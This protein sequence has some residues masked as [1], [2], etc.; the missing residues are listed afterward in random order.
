MAVELKYQ[1][2]FT[3]TGD[4]TLNMRADLMVC[5]PRR[6]ISCDFSIE[7]VHAL[8]ALN[9]G[10][11]RSRRRADV[12][13]AV[14]SLRPGLP[15]RIVIQERRRAKGSRLSAKHQ[16]PPL[17]HTH[18]H[19]HTHTHTHNCFSFVHKCIKHPQESKI[20]PSK[21]SKAPRLCQSTFA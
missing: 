9:R 11:S 8:D 1:Q 3:R 19:V 13:A 21:S 16:P 7:Q 15:G 14:C 2:P 5:L 4:C 17:P 18:K 10:S 6:V 20:R 12:S